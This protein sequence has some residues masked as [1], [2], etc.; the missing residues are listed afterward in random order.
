MNLFKFQSILLVGFVAVAYVKAEDYLKCSSDEHLMDP[1]E[2]P[3]H[4]DGLPTYFPYPYDCS[5]YFECTNGAAR[6]IQC[7]VGTVW[8]QDLLV[9]NHEASTPCNIITTSRTTTT[10]QTTTT[11]TTT[12][13]TTTT[14]TT[15]TP[16]TTTP[17]TTT[18]TTTTP[19]T[20]TP[21]TTT[22][23]TTTPTT[24]TPT[25]TTPTTTTPTTTTPTT[26][27][28][29]TTDDPAN[30]ICPEGFVGPIRHPFTCSQFYICDPGRRPCLFEC[31]DGLFYNPEIEDC[32][33]P[34]NVPSCE[35][36]TPPPPAIGS[37]FTN[38]RNIQRTSLVND[39]KLKLRNGNDPCQA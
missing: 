32:D 29:T 12:T 30:W 6:C 27:P 17:T 35:G 21:T 3:G 11:P 18:P 4:E 26:T 24:T 7:A 33:W 2:C 31:P 19:T 38:Y 13:P 36:G 37:S 9:C 34:F 14:P 28:P 16:T 25:T 1:P 23:T 5:K 22:P 39:L 20:T 8:D 10:E 15:T